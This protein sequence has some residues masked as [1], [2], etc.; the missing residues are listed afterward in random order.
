LASDDYDTSNFLLPVEEVEFDRIAKENLN[1]LRAPDKKLAIDK[2]LPG[3]SLKI[4]GEPIDFIKKTWLLGHPL[5]EKHHQNTRFIFYHGSRDSSSTTDA[6]IFSTEK[7]FG[8]IAFYGVLSRKRKVFLAANSIIVEKSNP[9]KPLYVLVRLKLEFGL[10]GNVFFVVYNIADDEISISSTGEWQKDPF[11]WLAEQQ[12]EPNFELKGPEISALIKKAFEMYLYHMLAGSMLYDEARAIKRSCTCPW[13]SK[14]A[15]LEGG[16][17]LEKNQ[18]CTH[19]IV[20]EAEETDVHL[21]KEVDQ[22][23]EVKT[24]AHNVGE[25]I[26]VNPLIIYY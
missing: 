13:E 2:E 24:F 21:I 20:F 12:L 10:C 16:W 22:F 9:D 1:G 5:T 26:L 18:K 25:V 17:S 6:E 7:L 8:S 3:F 19:N 4:N 11:K 23:P 15:L 14:K